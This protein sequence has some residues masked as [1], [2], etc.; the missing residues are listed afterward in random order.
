[1][2]VDSGSTFNFSSLN[3]NFKTEN[4]NR[5]LADGSTQNLTEKQGTV[6]IGMR[7]EA[8]KVCEGKL[9]DMLY[10][11]LFPQDISISAATMKGYYSYFWSRFFLT[12]DS[13]Q[14]TISHQGGR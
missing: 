14:R 10:I 7:N 13:R 4:H 11:P 12:C 2:L 6:N 5:E 1:M 9:D 8:G 3:E